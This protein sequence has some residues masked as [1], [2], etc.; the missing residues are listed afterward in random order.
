[1]TE[2]AIA[3]VARTPLVVSPHLRA[4]WSGSQCRV[5]HVHGRLE[6]LKGSSD[7]RGGKA[8]DIA[9]A[10]LRAKTDNDLPAAFDLVDLLWD[11]RAADALADLIFER[12]VS[13][14][15]IFPTPAFDDDMTVDADAGYRAG[16]RNAIPFA[17]VARLK[18]E[19]GGEE[20][21]EIVQAARV[22]RTKLNLFPR[23]LWQPS[24]QGG[25]E[26]GRS[27]LLA[28]DVVTTA[29]TF[30]A[31]RSFI[32]A[33]G[34]EVLGATALANSEG[35]NAPFA[36]TTPTFRL[37]CQNFGD[38]FPGFWKEVIGHDAA[39]LTEAEGQ[40][41]LSWIGRHHAGRAT[42]LPRL[43]ILRARLDKARATGE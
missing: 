15:W 18:A 42:G 12:G 40:R 11:S 14:I 41:L 29:G 9:D 1:M 7:G 25:V 22:G 33:K 24:F 38:A 31:L 23:F 32:V 2:P 36:L 37:L 13:P 16:P 5:V 10:Y 35:K 27:Y 43:H 3:A 20:N 26:P 28:D 30:A 39:F 34:G 4:A 19:L 21:V 8:Q 6:R 17:F